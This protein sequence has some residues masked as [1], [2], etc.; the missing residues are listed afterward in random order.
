MSRGPGIIERAIL[1]EISQIDS[2]GTPRTVLVNSGALAY[3]VFKPDGWAEGW[4]PTLSQRKSVTRAMRAFCRKSNRYALAGGK[5][6][7]DLY[8]FDTTDKLSVE[9]ARLRTADRMTAVKAARCNSKTTKGG[10]PIVGKKRPFVCRQD[11]ITS[12]AATDPEFAA[13]RAQTADV[14]MAVYCSGPATAARFSGRD[15]HP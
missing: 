2:D 5:G 13:E 6:R 12:L 7:M 9:W 15:G 11:A 8:L 14:R 4:H 10:R 3:C 1:E